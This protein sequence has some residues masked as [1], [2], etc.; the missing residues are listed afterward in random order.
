MRIIILLLASAFFITGCSSSNVYFETP[1]GLKS[2]EKQ[3]KFIY[4]YKPYFYGL[5]FFV[6]P[7]HGGADRHNRGYE[8]KAVEADLNLRVALALRSFLVEAGAEVELS[9]TDDS[10]V[11]LKERS[12]L[13][14]S[15]DADFFISIHHNAPGKS[16]DHS[17]DYTSTYYHAFPK[18]YEYE[19]CN[20]DLAR[21]VQRDLAY[22]M[23]NSGG[24]GSFD[25][26]YSDYMIYPGEGFSVLRLSKM[27]AILVECGFNTQ[28]FEAKRLVLEKFNKIE[29]WGIFRGICRYLKAGIP[30]IKMLNSDSTFIK[31]DL[32]FNFE[33]SDSSVIVPSSIEVQF[34]SS[35]VFN[36]IYNPV[37]KLLTV[38]VSG[39]EPG[40]H[41][42]RVIAAN[43]NKNHAFPFH[44]EII[45]L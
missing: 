29:A 42:I 6:D 25:G 44:K 16:D 27:P 34:D 14:K 13:A 41:Q 24:L 19:P 26:T 8:N 43:K 1:I 31:G 15:S 3:K 11:E 20:H 2:K 36:N 23:R 33:I 39:V 37:T 9:R 45:V 38:K 28:H 7:G 17:T 5:N 18:D 21:Y 10:T 40:K 22:A 32:S 4:N 12:E 35:C 30:R